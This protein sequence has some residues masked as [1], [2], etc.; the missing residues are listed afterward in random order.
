MTTH[1]IVNM[2][3]YCHSMGAIN[4]EKGA[5]SKDAAGVGSV[6]DFIFVFQYANRRS[7]I[8]VRRHEHAHP[9]ITA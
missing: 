4:L 2:T 1:Q 8:T 7:D 9:N 3:I 5:A 6:V